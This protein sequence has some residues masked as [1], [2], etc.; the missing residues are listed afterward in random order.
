MQ[1]MW[2]LLTL[3]LST[4]FMIHQVFGHSTNGRSD[5]CQPDMPQVVDM[6]HT[7]GPKTLFWPGD[8]EYKFEI[9]YRGELTIAPGEW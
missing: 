7:H 3:L 6:T 4:T 5:K 2:L 9:V 1:K 8:P